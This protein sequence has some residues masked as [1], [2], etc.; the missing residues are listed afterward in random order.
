MP[1]LMSFPTIRALTLPWCMNNRH[2]DDWTELAVKWCYGIGSALIVA[3][4]AAWLTFVY[5]GISSAQ[6]INALQ[7]QKLAGIEEC[8]RSFKDTLGRIE[9]KVDKT[10][11]KMEKLYELRMK[12]VS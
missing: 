11:Q 5:S 2:E 7:D 10:D 4:I 9:I 8:L 3:C 1:G 6:S 12:N